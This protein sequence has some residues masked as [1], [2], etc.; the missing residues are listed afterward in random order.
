MTPEAMLDMLYKKSDKPSEDLSAYWHQAASPELKFFHSNEKTGKWC[1]FVDKSEVDAAWKKI[2]K[3]VK[4]NKL[5]LAKVSTATGRIRYGDTHVICVYTHD[6]TDET[7]LKATREVLRKAGFIEPL[8]YKRD[9]Q[10]RDGVYGGDNE[11]Y[12]TM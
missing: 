7:E 12:L 1:I 3:A 8:K 6:W 2:Q 11:Y 5:F 9:Q 4:S 10:T